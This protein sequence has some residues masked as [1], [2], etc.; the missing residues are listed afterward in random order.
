MAINSTKLLPGSKTS[1]TSKGTA[2]RMASAFDRN[3]DMLIDSAQTPSK[4]L[5]GQGKKVL[6]I[7]TQVIKIENLIKR[8]YVEESK[9]KKEDDKNKEKLARK[10]REEK[11]EEKPKQDEKL[12]K[13][14]SLPKMG[15]LDGIKNFLVNLV[16]GFVAFRLIEHLPKIVKF[17]R[18]LAPAVDFFI[19]FSGK[20]LDGLITFIDW[21]YKAY[22]A[23]RGFVKTMGGNTALKIFDGFNDAVGKVI[24]AAIIASIALS[25]MGDSGGGGYGGG[26][27]KR[28]FDTTGRRIGKDAQKRYFQRYGRERFIE[29]FGEENLKNLPKSAARSGLTKVARKSFVGLVGKAGAKA[30]LGFAKP[31]LKRLPIIGGLIDFGLSV[32]LGEDPGRAAF[33]AIG[34]TLVG[35]IG[36]AIGSL[37]FGAGA[38][39]GGIIGGIGGDMLGGALYDM[40]FGGKKPT[41]KG[42]T[43]KAAGGGSATRGGKLVSGDVKRSVK[44]QKITRIVK[45]KPESITPGKDI[46]GKDNIEKIFPESKQKDTINPLGYLSETSNT[47]GKAAFFG[48]L[49]NIALKTILGNKPT[50]LDYKNVGI[51]LNA[52]LSKTLSSSGGFAGGGEVDTSMFMNGED[53]SNV[54]ASSVKDSVSYE[55]DKTIKDLMQNL[56]LKPM[57]D[58]KAGGGNKSQE[59]D[60]PP[61]TGSLTG[62]TNAEKVFNY[63]VS[64]GFTPQAAAGVI[65]NLM[66]ESGVNPN[67]NQHGGGPGRGIM[68]WGTGPGSGQRWDALTAWAQAS[69][70]DPRSL[71]TQVEWMMKE[72]HQRGTFK[73]LKGLTNVKAATDLFEKEMEGAGTPMMENRYKHAADALASFGGGTAGGTGMAGMDRGGVGGSIAEYITGDP[74][75]PFGRFDRAGHG[76]P[77]NYHDHIAF[78]DRNT[79]VSAYNFFKSKGIQ[80]T[81]FKGFDSVGGHAS[82]SYHYSGLAF[83]VPGAQWGGSGAIGSRDYAGSAKVRNVLKQFMGGDVKLAKGGL[84]GGMT[85]AMIGEKGPEYV[86]DSDTTLSLNTNMPG[87]LDK[88]NRAKN[89]RNIMSVIQSYASY[90]DG[91]E[92]EVVLPDNYGSSDE[93]EDMMPKSSQFVPVPIGGSGSSDPFAVLDRLP[94]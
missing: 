5:V 20:L 12:S 28:G 2:Q 35:A 85:R 84:V 45:V 60:L 73:R 19:D 62:N 21:G 94:G 41:P 23:T 18:I 36:A 92:S 49:F 32:A 53:Y 37:A 26:G 42:K 79:A 57:E 78:K 33:K 68:Q 1:T 7:K 4:S 65:G 70:K 27:G 22:D 77:G 16:L 86:L 52:W 46:G 66:Q 61:G 11:L 31:L 71:D 44:K 80:V 25:G 10:K 72:M 64:Y 89:I 43:A 75:T 17:A 63:L 48:P 90:E 93:S 40:F 15:F 59:G 30:V 82:G 67:S 50:N 14:I 24:D 9:R 87:F 51:G 88:L 13:V 55:I 8:K 6:I 54:I 69:G 58:G 34:A 91:A 74:N 39:I 47:L 3:L 38:I 29:R 83:D 56:M 76:T 81:E